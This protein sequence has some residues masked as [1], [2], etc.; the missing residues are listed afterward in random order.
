MGPMHVIPA[1]LAINITPVIVVGGGGGDHHHASR[2]RYIHVFRDERYTFV[3]ASH[4]Y[5]C[6]LRRLLST[7][8]IIFLN[9]VQRHP[10]PPMHHASSLHDDAL[11]RSTVTGHSIVA[12]FPTSYHD[13]LA[14]TANTHKSRVAID[15]RKQRETTIPRI[16]PFSPSSHIPQLYRA[17]GR[18]H[19]ATRRAHFLRQTRIEIDQS[20]AALF[21][22]SQLAARRPTAAD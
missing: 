10:K 19:N 21:D 1:R 2:L 14:T 20:Q 4:S 6:P 3:P 13:H 16:P 5:Q 22:Q 7:V 9:S 11:H 8:W 18:H 12:S 15:I 17:L